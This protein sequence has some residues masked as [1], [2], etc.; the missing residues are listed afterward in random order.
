MALP[1]LSDAVTPPRK[2]FSTWS[3]ISSN[4]NLIK[5]LAGIREPT[6]TV[7]AGR[8]REIYPRADARPIFEAVASPDKTL[9]E[10]EDARHY[11]EPDL[12]AKDAP[13]VERLMDVV[14]ACRSVSGRSPSASPARASR[15]IT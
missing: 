5:N 2:G 9:V 6:L 13:H 14:L 4:A 11:F 15:A 10:L 12:G 1:R 7:F 3:A 8:D